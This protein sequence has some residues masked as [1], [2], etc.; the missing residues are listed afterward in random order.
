MKKINFIDLTGCYG[1]ITKLIYSELINYLDE[2]TY[3]YSKKFDND[4]INV[5]GNLEKSHLDEIGFNE[6][7]ISMLIPHGFSHKG[8]FTRKSVIYGTNN[9]SYIL[10]SGER[11]KNYLVSI[12]VPNEKILVFGSP[13]CDYLYKKQQFINEKENC[14]VYCPTHTNDPSSSYFKFLKYTE[15]L[16]DKYN[17]II[18]PHPFNSTNN[19]PSVDSICKSKVVIC[20]NGSALH[21]SMILH[22]ATVCLDF[23]SGDIIKNSDNL[24]EKEIYE[25]KV[26]YHV[27][28]ENDI[29]DVIDKALK[30]G[31]TEKSK[32]FAESMVSNETIGKC[33]LLLKN[34]IENIF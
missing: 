20:D 34:Y 26:N 4:M 32:K 25:N 21:E 33:G 28:D 13:K 2:G 15:M 27:E 18:S 9:I 10:A 22:K 31:Q 16:G 3:Q 12:G 29:I 7:G 23:I 1:S 19:E 6:N 11:W 8:Y 24:F 30:Y 17:Y 5:V 14:V